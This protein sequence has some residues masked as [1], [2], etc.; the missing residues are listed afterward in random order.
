MPLNNFIKT[1]VLYLAT[2]VCS[3]FNPPEA[4][5][6]CEVRF[7]ITNKYSFNLHFNEP[8]LSFSCALMLLALLMILL[9]KNDYKTAL[10]Q[11]RSFNAEC[12]NIM[13]KT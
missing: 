1:I 3:L 9:C 7:D 4:L 2:S 11:K 8:V 5:D 10:T 12:T 6:L 13:L